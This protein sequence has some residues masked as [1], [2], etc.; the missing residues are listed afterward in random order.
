M[1][2]LVKVLIQTKSTFNFVHNFFKFYSEN[3]LFCKYISNDV[4]SFCCEFYAIKLT[5]VSEFDY[6][7]SSR[8][9]IQFSHLLNIHWPFGNGII[10][11][12]FNGDSYFVAFVL[13]YL[14][15]ALQTCARIVSWK[16]YCLWSWGFIDHFR[17]QRNISKSV[18]FQLKLYLFY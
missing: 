12:K 3:D 17:L 4:K 11:V 6:K 14:C 1:F 7:N 15:F 2:L 13:Q 18:L 9:I 10:S 16:Y 5:I 8:Q